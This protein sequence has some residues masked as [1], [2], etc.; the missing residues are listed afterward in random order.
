MSR[1]PDAYCIF[2]SSVAHRVSRGVEHGVMGWSEKIPSQRRPA[3]MRVLDSVSVN[4][5]LEE[6][7]Q[8]RLD[9]EEELEERIFWVAVFQAMGLPPGF[10]NGC[11]SGERKPM[12]TKT[13][14]N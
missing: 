4:V 7:A 5:V 6:M 13:R 9:S 3:I 11:S 2:S 1:S 10:K 14:I 8:M 12:S